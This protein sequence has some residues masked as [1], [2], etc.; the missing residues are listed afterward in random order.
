MTPHFARSLTASLGLHLTVAGAALLLLMMGP[1]VSLEP[2]APRIITLLPNGLVSDPGPANADRAPQVVLPIPKPPV[3]TPEPQIDSTSV[4][5]PVTTPRPPKPVAPPSA[6]P[7]PPQL[8]ATSS[9]ATTS[10]GSKM[11]YE[12]FIH[13]H[14]QPKPTKKKPGPTTRSPQISTAFIEDTISSSSPTTPSA[15]PHFL[16]L[17]SAH[18]RS[19]FKAS[20]TWPEN[21]AA[22][23]SFTVRAD[24]T[25][26]DIALVQ[27]SG[28]ADFDAAALASCR[29]IRLPAVPPGEVG[30]SH[31]VQFRSVPQR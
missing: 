17:L 31:R 13:Q 12:E 28:L 22:L 14:G 3:T 20:G 5:P 4:A 21:F 26:G 8:P 27:K 9:T 6:R 10:S 1:R 11:S 29:R 7:T 15:D 25:L 23:V 24:G 18:L 2:D 19:A 16:D 30:Q